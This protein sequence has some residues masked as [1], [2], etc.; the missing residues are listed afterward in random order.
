M[1]VDVLIIPFFG[2]VSPAASHSQSMR[3]DL[4][5][6]IS[7]GMG[8]PGTLLDKHSSQTSPRL[9]IPL[10]PAGPLPLAPASNP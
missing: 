1:L 6:T 3:Y 9:R 10:S 8:T 5:G 4:H 2:F 7:A